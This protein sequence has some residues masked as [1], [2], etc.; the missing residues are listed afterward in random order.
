VSLL[1]QQYN[2]NLIRRTNAEIYFEGFALDDEKDKWVTKFINLI[3]EANELLSQIEQSD[4][5]VSD[6]EILNG[7]QEEA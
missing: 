6:N 5:K 2:K 1:K 7:F 4:Y 3:K